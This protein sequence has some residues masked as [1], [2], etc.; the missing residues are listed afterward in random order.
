MPDARPA[1]SAGAKRACGPGP[2]GWGS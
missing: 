2:T 1:L